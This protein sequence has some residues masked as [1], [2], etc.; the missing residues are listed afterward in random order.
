MSR[1]QHGDADSGAASSDAG[2]APETAA[3]DA[4]RDPTVEFAR[5]LDVG[6][7]VKRAVA[8]AGTFSALLYVVFV[9][10]PAETT[11]SPVLYLALAF[12]IFFATSLLL[13]IAF[14]LVS[15]WRLSREL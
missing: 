6:R 5:A 8:I 15:A 2:A 10:V 3:G 12:V 11:Q 9:V 4:D 14:T 7:N 1:D 13:S